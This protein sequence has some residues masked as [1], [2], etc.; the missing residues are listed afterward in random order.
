M[1]YGNVLSH[2]ASPV[3][4]KPS[5][6]SPEILPFHINMAGVDTDDTTAIGPNLRETV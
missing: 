2:S 4:Y 5:P 6:E 3:Q 1:C